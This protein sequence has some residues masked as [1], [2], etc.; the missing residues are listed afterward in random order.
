MMKVCD[1]ARTETLEHVIIPD[2]CTLTNYEGNTQIRFSTK[3]I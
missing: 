3:N 1:S 2:Y